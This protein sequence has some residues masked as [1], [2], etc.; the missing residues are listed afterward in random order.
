MNDGK[1]ELDELRE[2]VREFLAAKSPESAVRAATDPRFIV[3]VR[4][5]ADEDWEIGLN[6]TEG[7]KI[8]RHLVAGGKVD[9]LNVIRGHM[10]TDA[11]LTKLIPI[12]GMRAAPHLDFAGEVRG[13]AAAA[14]ALIAARVAIAQ[15]ERF[16]RTGGC[17][18]G[19][20]GFSAG[21]GGEDAVSLDGGAAAAIED[22]EA[23]EAGYLR[24][25]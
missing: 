23:F 7:I 16:G 9:F 12:I 19:D 21:A 14:F 22:F 2:A 6:R 18:A 11:A 4:M 13:G 15:F 5:V 17:A 10:D 24:H 20:G 8:A 1:E 3:G 25:Y